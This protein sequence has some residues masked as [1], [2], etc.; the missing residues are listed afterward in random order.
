MKNNAA[1]HTIDQNY[2]YPETS[3]KKHK[4]NLVHIFCKGKKQRGTT[5]GATSLMYVKFLT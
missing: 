5:L 2:G 1:F 3:K 4:I